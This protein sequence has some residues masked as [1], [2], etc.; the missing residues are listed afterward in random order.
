MRVVLDYT[1]PRGYVEAVVLDDGVR[2]RLEG[3]CN[4]CGACCERSLAPEPHRQADGSCAQLSYETVDGARVACCGVM[5]NRPMS[6][7]LYPRDPH[8]P[9]PA[10]CG[11]RW[12]REASDG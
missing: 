12:V 9:L 4:R 11:Y 1:H 7:A 10:E 2:W 8:D 3:A 6:C 5:W